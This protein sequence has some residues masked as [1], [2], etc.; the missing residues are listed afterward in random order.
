M[1]HGEFNRDGFIKIQ[2]FYTFQ[3]L[4]GS[5][6][7]FDLKLETHLL[8]NCRF[9][10]KGWDHFHLMQNRLLYKTISSKSCSF[11][12]IYLESSLRVEEKFFP[13]NIKSSQCRDQSK[14]H[15]PFYCV[16]SFEPPDK[17]LSND[18]SLVV[19][20]CVSKKL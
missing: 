18:V 5:L 16:I 19:M 7:F 9:N 13:S 11:E 10:V 2:R 8:I 15:C 1:I 12:S 17:G 6:D 4:C 14:N 20:A 3:K